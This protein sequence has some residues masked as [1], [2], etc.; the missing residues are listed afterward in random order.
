MSNAVIIDAV[1]TPVAKGKPG[2][3][4]SEVHPVDL[5][6]HVLRS[7]VDRTGIDPAIVDDVISGTVGQVGEQSGNTARW[8]VLGAG[9]PET[10]PAVT[11]D[12]QC[13]SSQQAVHFAAQGVIAGA[14]DVAIASGVESMSHVP[15]GSQSLGR[16][17]LG[18][19]VQERYDGGLVPQGISAELIS[20]R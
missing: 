3:A 7:L 8:A 9:F 16:D 18:T 12:R 4:Y 1:R 15:I 6:A 10:V 17:F 14:Y 2:G 11:V 20:Q 19:E 5:H 13:G